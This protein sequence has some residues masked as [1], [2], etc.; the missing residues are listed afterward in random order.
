MKAFTS[1]VCIYDSTANGG[2]FVDSILVPLENGDDL[3]IWLY[4]NGYNQEVI[5]PRHVSKTRRDHWF[6]YARAMKFE[7]KE[8]DIPDSL[9]QE[10]NSIIRHNK[11]FHNLRPLFARLLQ[12][13]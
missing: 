11:R 13:A 12:A 6:E 10:A 9:I 2:K 1:E 7:I 8:V 4:R 5:K 3:E